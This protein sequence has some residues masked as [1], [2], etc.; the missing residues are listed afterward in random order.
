MGSHGAHGPWAHV[1]VRYTPWAAAAAAAAAAGPAAVKSGPGPAA[2]KSGPAGPRLPSEKS[3]AAAAAKA[4]AAAMLAA[5]GAAACLYKKYGVGRA[6]QPR[7]AAAW[8][9]KLLTQLAKSLLLTEAFAE[10][11]AAADFSDGNLGPGNNN[12]TN[13]SELMLITVTVISTGHA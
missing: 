2:S 10:A 1:N 5:A 8:R 6:A 11:F 12:T 9:M 7:G 4:S 3:A 13:N